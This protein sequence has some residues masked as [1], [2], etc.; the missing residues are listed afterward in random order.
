M[1]MMNDIIRERRK[2]L[3]LTQKELADMLFIS[4]KTV[5]RWESGNQIPDAML[6]PDLV[7]ALKISINDLYGLKKDEPNTTAT[8]S[9]SQFPKVKAWIITGYKIA[10]TL[11]LIL[12]LFGS[13]LLIH[14][15]SINM[16]QGEERYPGN[17]FLYVS[18]ATCFAL[19]ISYIIIYRNKSL[20]NP[21]YLC[22][23]IKL[24]GLCAL[25]IS[26]VTMVVFPFFLAVKVS[27]WYELVTIILLIVFEVML[28]SQK[29]KLR[30]EGVDIGKKIS[31]ISVAV[32]SV[33]A[34]TVL[35]VF[36]YF[37]FIY[38]D[39]SELWVRLIYEL[40]G[41]NLFES[42][43]RLYSYMLLSYFMVSALLMNYIQILIKVKNQPAARSDW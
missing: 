5:S 18:I 16:I 28:L 2:E 22:E 24:G 27:Y 3:G 23:D 8:L 35:G 36:I 12:F 6:L 43:V 42:K 26:I 17:M 34:L 11:S 7:E 21:L 19:E 39:D 31:I 20:Y 14:L 13:M 15:N 32:I 40:S 38:V 37:R 1:S 10:M 33:C 29:R 9:Q 25:C 41:G 4:D 30:S